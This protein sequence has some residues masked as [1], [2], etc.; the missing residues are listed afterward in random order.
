[1]TMAASAKVIKL[2]QLLNEKFPEAHAGVTEHRPRF[3]T[4]VTGLDQVGI[5]KGALTEIVSQPNSQGSSLLINGLLNA[6]QQNGYHLAL[7]DGQDSFDPQSAG[8]DACQRM[9][10]IRCRDADEALKAADL[11]FRDGNLPLSILDL[12]LN[13]D[14][15]LRRISKQVW[16]RLQTLVQRTQGV[17]M[18]L[19][20]RPMISSASVRFD[21]GNTFHLDDLERSQHE[22]IKHLVLPVTRHRSNLFPHSQ[23]RAS[24]T[25]LREAAS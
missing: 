8:H 22:L 10:W 20:P 15:E 18:I 23:P 11:I 21:L 14:H 13:T 3:P 17:G 19:T 2:R 4:G 25:G 9:L 24:D 7:I 12:R 6:A 5:P 16:Y 1:M